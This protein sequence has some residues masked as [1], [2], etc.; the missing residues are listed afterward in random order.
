MGGAGF[1]YV[2]QK[3]PPKLQPGWMIFPR[4]KTQ[5]AITSGSSWRWRWLMSFF[6]T[7][8]NMD[9]KWNLS[10]HVCGQGLAKTWH[11]LGGGL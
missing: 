11:Q 6:G 8:E 10:C 3:K 5:E 1:P 4:H 9:G 7:T 2:Q